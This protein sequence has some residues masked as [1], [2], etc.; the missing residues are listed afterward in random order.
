MQH[1]GTPLRGGKKVQFN[2]FL[3]KID[4][5][6]VTENLRTTLFPVLWVEEGIELN[7]DMVNLIKGDLVNVLILL[8]FVQWTLIGFGSALAVGMFSYFFCKKNSKLLSASVEP[9]YSV[10]GK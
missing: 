5:I 4:R 8:D 1:T 6:T 3:R 7:D 2:M 9:I 10:R